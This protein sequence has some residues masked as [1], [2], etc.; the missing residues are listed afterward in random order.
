MAIDRL[1]HWLW[2]HKRGSTTSSR[3][4]ALVF[5]PY[6]VSHSAYIAVLGIVMLSCF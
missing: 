5:Y 3:A 2:N 6:F 1:Q 4:V